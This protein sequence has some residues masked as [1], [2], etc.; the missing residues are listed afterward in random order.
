MHSVVRTAKVE[1]AGAIA[2]LLPDLGYEATV[3]Q[4]HL[5][6]QELLKSPKHVV[7][8]AEANGS[9]AGLCLVSSVRHLASSGYAE[10]LELVVEGKLQRQGIGSLLLK[11]AQVWAGQQGQSRLRLR[12]GIHRTEAHEFYERLGY[13]KSRASY[14][15]ELVLAEVGS[16]PSVKGTFCAKAQSAPYLER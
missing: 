4:V 6:L 13:S 9:V 2:V 5:R 8:V 3:E 1:D 16:N 12:S 11:H 14:A 15:F 10:V 7:L